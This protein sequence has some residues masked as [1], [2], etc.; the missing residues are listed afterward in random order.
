MIMGVLFAFLFF[1]LAF[2]PHIFPPTSKL[3]RK[4]KNPLACEWVGIFSL[5]LCLQIRPS[6]PI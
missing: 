6:P 3:G 5:P 4:T 1:R 2:L